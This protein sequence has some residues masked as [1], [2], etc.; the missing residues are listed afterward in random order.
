MPS[1][2]SSRQ[3]VG[4]NTEVNETIIDCI[5]KRAGDFFPKLRQTSLSE[6]R[7][8]RKV[9]VGLR[10]YSKLLTAF[11]DYDLFRLGFQ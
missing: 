2:G 9:R 10:P 5:W 4:Y 7:K 1:T 8:S 6:L 11:C 3:F